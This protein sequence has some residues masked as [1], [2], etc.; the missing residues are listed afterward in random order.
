MKFL[1]I[2][3]FVVVAVALLA[4]RA[5]RRGNP[6]KEADRSY[7]LLANTARYLL[8]VA[9]TIV[10]VFAVAVLAQVL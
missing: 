9:A 2:M 1:L 7:I 8:Y 6:S 4:G 10:V 5:R 3:A